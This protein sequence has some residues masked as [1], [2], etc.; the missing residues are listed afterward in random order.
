M[1]VFYLPPSSQDLTETKFGMIDFGLFLGF[2]YF[3]LW[4]L[5]ASRRFFGMR[6]EGAGRPQE[7]RGWGGGGF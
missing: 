5:C 1:E 4:E 6:G 3:F 2:G 7:G